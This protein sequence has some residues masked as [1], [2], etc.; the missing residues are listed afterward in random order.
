MATILHARLKKT[1]FL[2]WKLS[3]F[4]IPPKFVSW[5]PIDYKIIICLGNGLATANR[6][7]KKLADSMLT[8]IGDTIYK[9][10]FTA[11]RQVSV[12]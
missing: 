6:W 9:A 5:G 10:V 11:Q 8:E 2:E 4:Q 7:D 3:Y 1:K 12:M